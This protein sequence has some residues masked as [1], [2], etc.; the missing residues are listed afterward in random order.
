[1]RSTTT[2]TGAP[3]PG[4]AT[5]GLDISQSLM[6]ACAIHFENLEQSPKFDFDRSDLTDQ[7]RSVLQQIATCVTTGPLAGRHL[8]LI[9]R[10]DPRGEVEY[11][12]G[13]GAHRASSAASYLEHLGVSSSNVAETSR[14][15]LDA[16][17][18]D[19][20]S[21]QNDRRVDIDLR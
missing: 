8:Q 16:T 21:W 14:G 2:T 17:G 10:A 7:D 20:A 4:R 18:T 5:A 12:L 15:K 13:L 19:E 3:V 11:N 9:G 1:M 6:Q